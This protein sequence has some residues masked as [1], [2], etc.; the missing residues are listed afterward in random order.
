MSD[1]IRDAIVATLQSVPDIGRVH[2]YARNVNTAADVQAHYGYNG[3]LR[4][5]FVRRMKIEE[6]VVGQAPRERIEWLIRGYLALKDASATEPTFDLLIDRIRE[7]FRA[8][9]RLQGSVVT[10]RTE[11]EGGIQLEDAGPTLL[12][13]VLCHSAMLRLV[14]IRRLPRAGTVSPVDGTGLV[15]AFAW[16]GDQIAIYGT[17]TGPHLTGP[18]GP[19]VLAVANYSPPRRYLASGAAAR[20]DFSFGNTIANRLYVFDYRLD[21]AITSIG[22]AC[23]LQTFVSALNFRLFFWDLNLDLTTGALLLDSGIMVSASAGYLA[24]TGNAVLPAGWYRTAFVCSGIASVQQAAQGG[25]TPEG[26]TTNGADINYRYA[27][28]VPLA[29][30]PDVNGM[31][32]TSAVGGTCPAIYL[33][34]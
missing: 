26:P 6:V 8:E 28:A 25:R 29:G 13:G 32:L 2:A 15:P 7:V 34:W 17:V 4:G 27:D 1:P 14:T 23:Y 10:T 21:S 12:A 19:S 16:R 33:R 30:V 18:A 11:E 20:I 5:W 9:Y 3:Q 31:T 22:L 24:S